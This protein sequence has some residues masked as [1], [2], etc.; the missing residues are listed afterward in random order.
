[1]ATHDSSHCT[2]I[3][4]CHVSLNVLKLDSEVGHGDADSSQQDPVLW[5]QQTNTHGLQKSCGE[6]EWHGHSLN[7]RG[8]EG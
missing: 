7:E 2:H 3:P 4:S 6:K 5:Q 8:Q 1:M